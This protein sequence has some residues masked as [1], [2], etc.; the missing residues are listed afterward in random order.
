MSGFDGKRRER[1][2]KALSNEGRKKERLDMPR[3]YNSFPSE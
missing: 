2:K 1:K 3:G